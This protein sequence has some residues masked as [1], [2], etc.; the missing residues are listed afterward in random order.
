[1]NDIVAGLLASTVAIKIPEDYDDACAFLVQL[2]EAAPDLRWND[3]SRLSSFCPTQLS[4]T[5]PSYF[6]CIPGG[7]LMW[8]SRSWLENSIDPPIELF[9]DADEVFFELPDLSDFL[10]DLL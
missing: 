7:G 1:M 3:R 8:D 9:V 2:A 6:H 5:D 4:Q 10:N